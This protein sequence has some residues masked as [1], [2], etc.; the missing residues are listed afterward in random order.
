[1]LQ[2]PMGSDI[3]DPLGQARKISISQAEPFLHRSYDLCNI[4]HYPFNFGIPLNF[5]ILS[6]FLLSYCYR[7]LSSFQTFTIFSISV[8]LTSFVIPPTFAIYYLRHL[9]TAGLYIFLP[10]FHTTVSMLLTRSSSQN[11][12]GLPQCHPIF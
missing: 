10:V 12:N 9:F 6:T 3:I 11:T 1:M 5:V 7:L 4:P 2:Y 8:I